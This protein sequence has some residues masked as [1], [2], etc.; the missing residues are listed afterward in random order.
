[1]KYCFFLLKYNKFYTNAIQAE[2]V[3]QLSLSKLYSSQ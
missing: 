3:S 2:T 1:M